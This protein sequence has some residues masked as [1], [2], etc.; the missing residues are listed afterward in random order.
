MLKE[1]LTTFSFVGSVLE[2]HGGMNMKERNASLMES[3][4]ISPDAKQD[5]ILIQLQ[6]GGTGLNLQHYDRIIFNSPWWTSA[7]MDQAI[8]R[9]VRI[10][11]KEVVKVYWL[12]L[13]AE[14]TLNIDNFIMEKA[15]MKRDLGSKFLSWSV[16]RQV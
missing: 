4:I 10:G 14:T 12:K 11:Q 6:S 2:Y 8:G 3:K 9:A 1:F 13:K 7:L 16:G 15:D 5:V